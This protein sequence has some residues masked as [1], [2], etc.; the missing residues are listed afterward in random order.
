[1][2]RNRNYLFS[3]FDLRQSLENHEN[4]MYREIDAIDPN[5]LLNTSVD[6]LCNYY[7]DEYVA[8]PPRLHDDQITIDQGET[9]IDVSHDRD[10]YIRDRS[11]PFHITGIAVTFFVPFEG[12][13]ELFKCRP[14]ASTSAPPRAEVGNGELRMRYDKS[15]HDA[16]R[17]KAEFQREL[18]E[19]NR[20]LEWVQ[21]DVAA[22]NK[23]IRQKAETRINH[24]REKLLKDQG[25]V[26]GLGFPMR[27]RADAPK[28]YVAPE[29]RRK[30]KI[31]MP[32]ASTQPY[33]QEP[34]LDIGDYEHILKVVNN[35][36]LVMERSPHAFHDMN[37]EDL[38]QHFLV[39][40]NGQYEG[41]ATGETFNYQ[42]KTDILIR[43]DGKNI[44][45]GECK[46]WH[47]PKGFTETI[48]QLLGY[49]CWRDTKTSIFVFNRQKNLSK[50]IEQIPGLMENHSN[51]KRWEKYK[52]ETGSRAVF[53]H[54]D[55]KN[56][57]I[58][59]TVLIFDIPTKH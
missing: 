11:K 53:H 42:G 57:E 22:F 54:N 43:V 10:R 35:M 17:L 24:R 50:V 9:R 59:M 4:D 34:I 36:V 26:A 49:T 14:S 7:E 21:K 38:R 47:G 40:L 56:R 18:G 58:I 6:D 2:P 44:F 15:D 5:R 55:D 1:M 37:E 13:S 8:D 25:L 27:E 32:K 3:D 33:V 45:I 29:V 23:T 46:F 12:E 20:Y 19:I 39:Q 16:E 52:T 28:T 41:Q 30:P 51:F 48:D 31:E